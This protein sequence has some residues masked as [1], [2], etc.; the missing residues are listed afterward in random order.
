MTYAWDHTHFRKNVDKVYIDAY[1]YAQMGVTMRRVDNRI[2]GP[3]VPEPPRDVRQ[4]PVRG[5]EMLR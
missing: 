2:G 5:N 3:G 1:A 4:V